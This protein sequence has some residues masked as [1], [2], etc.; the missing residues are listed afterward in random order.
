MRGMLCLFSVAAITHA[1]AQSSAGPYYEFRKKAD[2]FYFAGNYREAAVNYV[3]A[4]KMRSI[5]TESDDLYNAACCL[6]LSNEKDSAF[7]LLTHMVTELGY[8][9]A[10]HLS[11]D[12]DLHILHQEKKWKDLLDLVAKNKKKME[13][14]LDKALVA[15]LNVIYADDQNGRLKD[16][17]A[18]GQPGLN[19]IERKALW[20]NIREK[21]SLNQVKVKAIFERYGWPPL[22]MIGKQG[23]Y[24]LF[25]VIQ[26]SDLKTQETYLP[27]MR[28]AVQD[29][30]AQGKYLALLEDRV[31]L[32][33]G[34][35]QIY[36]S[37]IGTDAKTG[38]DY[39]R[40]LED[41]DHVDERRFAV[42]LESY[43][44]YLQK[45]EMTWDAARYKQD[46]PAIEKREKR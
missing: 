38:R 35:K 10:D 11:Q 2:S 43:A 41:P 3:S 7:T 12:Q 33:Q 32:R 25:L 15:E 17:E 39:I 30:K 1:S 21:D 29:G 13:E 28:K 34:K 6:A 36:G 4:S 37:Q 5:R 23:S 42:G 31:A 18:D 19:S 45:F 44:D 27:L 16:E 9:D 20:D 24:T 8:V 14:G 46:L 26:H 22:A 40:P